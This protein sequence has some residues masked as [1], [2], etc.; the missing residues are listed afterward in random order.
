MVALAFAKDRRV[1]I[2]VQTMDAHELT[3]AI[4]HRVFA[5]RELSRLHR[6]D[7]QQKQVAFS[8]TWVIKEAYLKGIGCGLSQPLNELEV[9]SAGD[10][11]P[12]LCSIGKDHPD[13]SQWSVRELSF[14]DGY[15]AALAVEDP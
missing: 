11:H 8:R 7:E 1:G 15:A 5:P 6:F 4:A 12:R 3:P 2:D 10:E 14:A 13:T 9:V